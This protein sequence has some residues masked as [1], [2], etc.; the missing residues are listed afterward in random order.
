[1]SRKYRVSV[2]N[3]CL[4]AVFGAAMASTATAQELQPRIE[5]YKRVGQLELKAHV[6]ETQAPPQDKTR[7]AVVLFHGGGWSAGGPEWVYASARRYAALGMVAVAIQY[8]L[9]DQKSVTPLEAMDDARDAMRWVR[10]NARTLRID[11]DRIAGYG[12]SAGGQLVASTAWAGREKDGIDAA[13]NALLLY[14]PA[15]SV[16]DSGWVR[17]LLLGR[18][19]PESISPDKVANATFPPTLINQGEEDTLTTLPGAQGFCARVKQAGTKCEVRT[20]AGLGHLL[21]RNLSDQEDNYDADPAARADAR[22]AEERYL[23]ALGFIDASKV[24][25]HEGPEAVV[26]AHLADFNSRNVEAMARRVAEDF[27]WYNVDG[28]ENKIETRGREALRK[29]LEGYFKSVPTARSELY[30]LTTNGRFVSA[31][32]RVTWRNAK[33][34]PRSQNALS[35]YEVDE[36]L[37]KRVWYFPAVK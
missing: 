35:V 30:M 9:S 15:V 23:A 10:S 5:T 6:F 12:V 3:R 22:F 26:R 18:A 2:F 1:M 28:A 16:S 20:H 24:A 19:A 36:G 31:R 17:R 33:D 21:T 13:P 32:E 11:P 8:R 4:I 37:I 34:E 25:G 14:S 27:I 7:G 29:G